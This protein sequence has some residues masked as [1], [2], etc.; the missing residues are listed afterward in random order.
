MISILINNEPLDLPV[1]FSADMEDTSPIFNDK[2]SQS[3]PVTVPATG[4]NQRL[5][6]FPDRLDTAVDPNK[7]EILATVTAGAYIRRGKINVTSAGKK[8]GITFNIGFD[9]S[10]AYSEW[11]DKRLSD[12]SSLPVVNGSDVGYTDSV[13][14]LIHYLSNLYRGAV[15][16]VDPLAVFPVAIAKNVVQ[17]QDSKNLEKSFWEVLN[18]PANDTGAMEQSRMVKRVIDGEIVDVV[19]PE[20]YC[21]SPFVRVWKLLELAFADLGLKIKTNIFQ[22][23]ADFARLVVLN[24]AADAI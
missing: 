2:G 21:L 9:N 15:P 23:T 10:I 20:G 13:S 7:P 11:I 18:I 12:L 14:G 1:D 5:L 16:A 19:V 8:D 4:R 17:E 22:T 3:L 24:N 6:G